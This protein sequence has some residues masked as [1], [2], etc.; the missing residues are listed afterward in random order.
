MS[1][2]TFGDLRLLPVDY[3]R[4]V[5][6]EV[7]A[8]FHSFYRFGAASNRF[9]LGDAAYLDFLHNVLFG[10]MCIGAVVFLVLCVIVV[11]RTI[12]HIRSAFVR[13]TSMD[14]TSV[15]LLAVGLLTFLAIS[16]LGGLLGEAQVDYSA[17]VVLDTMTNTSDLFQETRELTTQSL[18]TSNALRVNA[19]NLITSFNDSELPAEAF[20]M[21]VE[22]LRLV[23]ASKE[24]LN[25]TDTLLPKN[26]SDIAK[27]W[28]FSYFMLKSSTNGAI[29]AVALASFLS[30]ASVG[31]AMVSPLRVS[32]LVILSV[33]PISHTLIGAYLSST[34]MTADF[35][36]APMNNT[37]E[38]VGTTSVA[39][40]YVECPAN[41]SLPFAD[42]MASVQQ[43]TSEVAKL[44]QEMERH[45]AHEG[46]TGQRMKREFLD[47]IGKQLDSVDTLMAE[48]A[49]SQTCKNVSRAF[50]Y[51]ATTYCE[52]G[53][54]G[55]FS[56]WVH[57][58][59]LCLIL[60]V[61][62]VVSVLVYERVHIRE[63][64]QDV[65]YQLLS[66]YE[67]DDMEHVYLSSD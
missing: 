46:E 25:Q 6:R 23:H 60:F 27:E 40:Y 53:M 48:F 38:L 2:S 43:I 22:A 50:E 7:A 20:K 65:R 31:W 10:S 30:I 24:L 8:F 61:S 16:A 36:A 54:L 63:I 37:L 51:A 57:Q 3:H 5:A 55:F 64:R 11:R 13:R 45:A 35:C 26:Y 19:D 44:Q 4:Q 66:S 14:S 32:I 62:V 28:E 56:M 39:N 52:Y 18:Q 29:L 1:S 59:L 33:V 12:L 34:I 9:D 15:E 47:P 67:E 42:V 49:A 58:I 41:A 21:S 17:G